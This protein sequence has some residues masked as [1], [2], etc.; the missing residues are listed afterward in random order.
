M[1]TVK[2]IHASLVNNGLSSREAAQTI[3]STMERSIHT[4]YGWI[5][6]RPPPR[7]TLELL[8]LKMVPRVGFEPT[9]HNF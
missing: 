4:V 5:G 7:D 9:K 1:K 6:H 3:A 2:E 8:N